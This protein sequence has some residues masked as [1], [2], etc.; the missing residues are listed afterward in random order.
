MPVRSMWA[1]IAAAGLFD[2][3]GFLLLLFAYRGGALSATTV[4]ASLY[5]AVAVLLGWVILHER[6]RRTQTIVGGNGAGHCP[7]YQRWLI[8]ITLAGLR[9][10]SRHDR[11]I[12]RLEFPPDPWTACVDT[13]RRELD[14]TDLFL[15]LGSGSPRNTVGWWG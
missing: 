4:L 13:A 9:R 10:R 14:T 7:T 1:L 5:P 6:L 11:V 8:S 15:R 2:T 12:V 3:M